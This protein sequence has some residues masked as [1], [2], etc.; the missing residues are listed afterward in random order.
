MSDRDPKDRESPESDDEPSAAFWHF[1]FTH[2]DRLQYISHLEDADV[3]TNLMQLILLEWAR[4]KPLGTL[5]IDTVA[6]NVF[7]REIAAIKRK[8]KQKFPAWQPQKAQEIPEPRGED[9]ERILRDPDRHLFLLTDSE[10]WKNVYAGALKTSARTGEEPLSYIWDAYVVLKRKIR[11]PNKQTEF[12]DPAGRETYTVDADTV[13]ADWQ[14]TA[15]KESERRGAPNRRIQE[16]CVSW[17][18]AM[19]DLCKWLKEV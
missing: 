4:Q 15:S 19:R 3:R 18:M 9:W 16:Y 13:D 14:R 8:T 6:M 7:L 1:I 12:F 5:R 17:R 2:P 11:K 10:L